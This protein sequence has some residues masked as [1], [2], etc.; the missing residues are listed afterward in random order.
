MKNLLIGFLVLGSFSTMAKEKSY[1]SFMRCTVG[2]YDA[3]P[4]AAF[5]GAIADAAML[6]VL[7][8]Q[9]SVYL[10]ANKMVYWL[11]CLRH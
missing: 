4:R 10:A 9:K 3:C 6:R 5:G 7:A 11:K 8:G 2:E 1:A